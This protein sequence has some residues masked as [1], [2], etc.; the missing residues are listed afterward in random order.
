MAAKSVIELWLWGGPSQLETFDPKPNASVDYNNGLKAIETN[1]PGVTI[2]EWWPELAKCADLYSLIRTMTHPYPGHETATYLMQT[3]RSPGGGDVYPAIGA[4]ISMMKQKDYRGDLPP[5]V[6]LTTA[7]GRFSE[8]G[9]LGEKYAPLVTGGDPR[10]PKFVVD[11]IVPPGALSAEDIA[12]RFDLLKLVDNFG[13]DHDFGNFI[14][15]GRQAR[16]VIEGS[17]AKTFDLSLESP[18]TRQRYGK[19]WIGQSLLAARRLVEYGVPYITVNMSGWDSHKRHFETMRQRTQET[20]RALAALL[21]DL[22]EKGLLDSTIVWV[23]GEFG[24]TT[25]VDRDPPWNGGRNHYPKCFSALVAGGGFKGGCVVGESDE[26]ASKVVKRPVT[27]VDFLGSIYELCGVDPDGPMP[28]PVGKKVT[29]LPPQS[30]HGRLKEIYKTFSSTGAST[31]RLALGWMMLASALLGAKTAAADPYVGYIYPAGVQAGTTN[32]VIV[33]G[34]AL[35]GAKTGVISGR[36]VRVLS[37]ENIPNFAPP[38]GPQRRYLEDWLKAIAEGRREKPPLPTDEKAHVNEWRSN[39]W[40]NALGD[41]DDLK[42]A[43]VERDLYTK[44]NSLQ[45]SPSLRQRVIATI[46]VDADAELGFRE[47]RLSGGN[48][49]SPPRPFEVSSAPRRAEPRFAAP[50]KPVPE[51]P[52]IENFPAALDGTIMPGETDGWRLRLRKGCAVSLRTVGRELQPYVGDAVPGFFNPTIRVLSPDGREVAFADDYFYH[53]DPELRFVPEADG[54]YTLEIRDVLYRGREDFVYTISAELDGALTPPSEVPLWPKPIDRIPDSAMIREVKGVVGETPDLELTIDEEGDYVFDLLA[55]RAGSPLDGRITIT[56][57]NPWWNLLGDR[58]TERFVFNDVTNTVFCGSII[59]GE[60][61]P[62]GTVH[63][64]P[65][66]Y[67]VKVEDE[68]FTLSPFHPFTLSPFFYTLR[69]HRPAPRFEVWMTPSSFTLRPG[70]VKQVKAFVLRRDG[71]KGAIHLPE[72]REFRFKPSVIPAATNMMKMTVFS[73]ATMPVLPSAVEIFASGR[74][75]SETVVTRV[76]PADEYNQ[77]FAWDHLLPSKS[78]IFRGIGGG[79]KVAKKGEKV[80]GE[81]VKGKGEKV[82]GK[83]KAKK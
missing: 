46:A 73:K 69:V 42:I 75:G 57:K 58:P 39:V 66:D 6:I 55:R 81:R 45:M 19:T 76:R 63:L 32:R 26:T 31:R 52:L 43:I 20:D 18:E 67:L 54:V 8:V 79:K 59:Q 68:R 10:Q 27:P 9:F 13:D 5:F 2:H 36:G 77:A 78:F 14:E 70:Q 60:C 62:I 61:D 65:G 34:Q 25:K 35:G 1:V 23:S 44:R 3:G 30:K 83:K 47:F 40:W 17:A 7:K 64:T 15:A 38:T 22:S 11:G 37:V 82:K 48:G 51:R 53:P 16:H 24:R 28:N 50:W 33:G 80:K 74:L 72:T 4:V 12:S 71:F 56:K 49:M 21:R 29:V 41:L